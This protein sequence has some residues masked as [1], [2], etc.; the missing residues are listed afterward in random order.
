MN[1]S[2]PRIAASLAV[3]A[4]AAAI[5][6]SA[7]A[8]HTTYVVSPT[9]N[10]A[11]TACSWRSQTGT[12]GVSIDPGF[13]YPADST[14]PDNLATQSFNDRI[15]GA[16]TRWNSWLS[17]ANH[18]RTMSRVS[19]GSHRIALRNRTPVVGGVTYL[20]YVFV[21]R[22]GDAGT[23]SDFGGRCPHQT[24]PDLN[25]ASVIIETRQMNEWFTQPDAQRSDWEKCGT[26]PAYASYWYYTCTKTHDFEAVMSHEL[27]HANG[28]MHPQAI[29]S[30]ASSSANCTNIP[31]RATMC[32]FTL[33]NS[34]YRS[35]MR[36]P[37]SPYDHESLH[38]H[39]AVK[40]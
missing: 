5:T 4:V 25:L 9:S 3:L 36:T 39:Y 8:N 27:G 13:P 37:D 28:L 1:W 40:Q 34:R 32:D 20:G 15:N 19:W 26:D 35:E 2:R 17:T 16:I 18:S 30:G 23:S 14:A 11:Y 6:P 38:R 31:S 7:S 33:N 12:V 22:A 10:L 24:D 21:Q 29:G